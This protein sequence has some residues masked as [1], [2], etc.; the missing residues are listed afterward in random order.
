VYNTRNAL[1]NTFYA[2]LIVEESQTYD[3]NG[4]ST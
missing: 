2:I 1:E 4:K 3:R